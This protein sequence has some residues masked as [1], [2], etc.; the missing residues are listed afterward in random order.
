MMDF[1]SVENFRY[2]LDQIIDMPDL[3]SNFH[4]AHR[5]TTTLLGLNVTNHLRIVESKDVVPT[6]NE[7]SRGEV[8]QSIVRKQDA[9]ELGL[10]SISEEDLSPPSAR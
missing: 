3:T 7:S 10:A 6:N 4:S 8:N 9:P 2:E 1:A 5:L